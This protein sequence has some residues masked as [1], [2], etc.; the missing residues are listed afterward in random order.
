MLYLFTGLGVFVLLTGGLL[1][2]LGQSNRTAEDNRE[3][4]KQ[5][6]KDSQVS[7]EVENLV[8]NMSDSDVANELQKWVRK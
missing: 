6:L 7:H 1:Y 2:K 4:L 5:V 8:D 3:Q